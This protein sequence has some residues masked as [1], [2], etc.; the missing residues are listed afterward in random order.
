MPDVPLLL[1]GLTHTYGTT[2][3][4]HDVS[5]AVRPGE[6]VALLGPSG[7]G[8]TT[9]LRAIAG[10]LVPDAGRISLHGRPVVADGRVQ[11]PAERR[12]VGLVFQE[13]ALFPHLDVAANIAFGM[14]RPVDPERIA[15]LLALTDLVG[16]HG[17]AP[18]ALSGGQQQRV[19][20]ARALAA[21]PTVLLL[22]EP[23]ANVDPALRLELGEGLRRIVSEAGTA[24]LLITHDRDEALGL[25]DRVVVLT[26]SDRGG[27]VAQDDVPH[28]IYAKP[29]SAVVAG[30]TGPARQ[31]P[32]RRD[33]DTLHTPL[34]PWPVHPDAL[35]TAQRAIVRPESLQLV[36]GP[37]PVARVRHAPPGWLV[38]VETP[39]GPVWVTA[40]TPPTTPTV[41][42]APRGPLW[43]VPESP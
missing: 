32:G 23:F 13:Y 6:L 27:T 15:A 4:L 31:V 34:G 43:A 35:S 30:L 17:R 39:I 28:A 21:G 12:R 9:L 10:L 41:G 25:A 2:P 24:A 3:V 29:A 18:H 42:L 37:H 40:S 1:E 14:P 11:V 8:K 5:F 38:Q 22:D 16:L 36:A 7:V 26:P 20:L 33:A 19:A